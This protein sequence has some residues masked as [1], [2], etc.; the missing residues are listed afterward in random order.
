MKLETVDEAIEITGVKCCVYGLAGAGKTVLTSTIDGTIIVLSAESGLLSLKNA[1]KEVKERM[2]IIQIKTL[3]DLGQAYE[4]LAS[5]KMADW[6]GIDSGSEIAEVLLG[7]KKAENKDARAAYGDMAD[8]MMDTFR[9]IRDLPN[10]N[11]VMTA[12]MTRIKDDFTNITSYVPMFPG[13]I[14]TNQVPYMFDEIFALRVE[15]DPT[16][17]TKLVRVLQTG[18]DISYD[19]KDRSG[20]LDLFEPANL[21][22][23]TRKIQGLPIAVAAVANVN[24]EKTEE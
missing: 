1:P 14:L 7:V 17:P 24:E 6:V 9:K 23:I 10:Y 22:H 8:D 5:K 20:M 16:D 15:Q 18:R 11:V 19:C 13:R 21:G 3:S 4:W 2:R 12:K